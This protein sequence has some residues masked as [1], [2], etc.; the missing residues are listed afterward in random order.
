MSDA[1]RIA[2]RLVREGAISREEEPAL[3]DPAVRADVER[4]L[5]E[6]GLVLASSAYSDFVAARLGDEAA[7][8]FDASNNLGLHADQLALLVI[9]WARLALPKRTASQSRELPGQSTLAATDR[10]EAVREFRPHVRLEAIVREFGE[11][12]GARTRIEGHVKRLRRL[13]FLGGRGEIVEAGPMLELALDGEKMT[14]FIRS[15]VV[16]SVLSRGDEI[17]ATAAGPDEADSLLE[18]LRAIGSDGVA[19]GRLEKETG[20]KPPA[21]KKLLATLVERGKVRRDGT[22]YNTVYRV[23]EE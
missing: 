18:V 15:T 22:R 8:G 13:G 20:R 9:L 19:M 14:R 4:R 6:V 7:A 5:G 12:I 23:I 11:V 2:A 1:A 10:R 16:E 3:D 17:S 21:L